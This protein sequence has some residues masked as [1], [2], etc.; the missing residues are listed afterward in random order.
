MKMKNYYEI[1]TFAMLD[2]TYLKDNSNIN[3]LSQQ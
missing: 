2:H 1:L 3:R